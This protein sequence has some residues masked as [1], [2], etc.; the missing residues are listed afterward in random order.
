MRDVGNP[1]FCKWIKPKAE[2]KNL[3]LL[4]LDVLMATIKTGLDCE[5]TINLNKK[6]YDALYEYQQKRYLKLCAYPDPEV[7][8]G[9][10]MVGIFFPR[11]RS[12]C[13]NDE[14]CGEES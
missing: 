10:W 2:E 8:G 3:T 9:I 6:D 5:I 11:P 14:R 12:V 4:F 13:L 7:N 1:V